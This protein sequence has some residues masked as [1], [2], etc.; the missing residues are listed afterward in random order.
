MKYLLTICRDGETVLAVASR[1]I[2]VAPSQETERQYAFDLLCNAL[3]VLVQAIPPYS[4]ETSEVPPEECHAGRAHP[5]DARLF[6]PYRLPPARI[7]A[8]ETL[9]AP[10]P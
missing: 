4:T 7:D 10:P 8:Q 6:G 3:E 2:V 9:G 5:R 1:N